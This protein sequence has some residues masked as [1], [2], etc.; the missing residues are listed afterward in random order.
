MNSRILAKQWTYKRYSQYESEMRKIAADWFK[1]K[2]YITDVKYPFILDKYSE[3]P[4]NI[5]IPEVVE[6]IKKELQEQEAFPLHKYI[7]HGLSSQALVF[8]LV[9]P[10]IV[11]DDVS[12]L[13]SL[14]CKKGIK[15]NSEKLTAEFEYDD[16]KLFNEDTG[17]PTSIDLVLKDETDTPVVF[18]ES[19][20][21]EKEFGTCSVYGLGDC[22]GR[23]PKDDLS[24]CYL[25][26]IGRS[27][28]DALVEYGFLDTPVGSDSCCALVNNYQYFRELLF[29][30]KKGGIFVLLYDQRNPTFFNSNGTQTR[31]LMDYLKKLTPARYHDRIAHISIQELVAE[32]EK[33]NN[34]GWINEFKVKYGLN[35]ITEGRSK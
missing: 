26:F 14:L 32:I 29:A 18:I 9:G 19:K 12:P 3:W 35:K 7:H 27:Y 23:N 34:N 6:Y 8:N 21:V 16:R 28:W 30:L 15:L 1:S 20:L 33:T 4:K 5:I 11:Q 13:I 10:M 31:G 22:D 24:S 2:G 25:H 17:Q